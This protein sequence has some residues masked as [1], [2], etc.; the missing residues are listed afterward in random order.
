MVPNIIKLTKNMSFWGIYAEEWHF[1]CQAALILFV[2]IFITLLLQKM[3][4]GWQNSPELIIYLYMW[5]ALLSRIVSSVK[6]WQRIGVTRW[7]RLKD[8]KLP[9]A[10][11]S[12]QGELCKNSSFV[13]CPPLYGARVINRSGTVVICILSPSSVFMQMKAFLFTIFHSV[14]LSGS[15]L[16]LLL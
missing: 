2:V 15:F 1:H 10:L 8:N 11:E 5:N 9:N 14:S 6:P 7:K 12:T 16:R 4:S 3:F 13:R